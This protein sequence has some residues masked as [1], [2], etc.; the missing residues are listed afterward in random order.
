MTIRLSRLAPF[1]LPLCLAGCSLLPT[2]RHLPVP[3]APARVQTLSPD[4][5]VAS[6]NQR[7]NALESLNAKV[8]IQASIEKPKEGLEK[9]YTTFPAIILLRKP[10][11]LRV[12]GRVPIVGTMMFD[13]AS[14]GKTFTM[15][16]PSRKEAIEGPNS[17][18]KVSP[19][20]IENMRPSF[21]FDAMVVRGLAPD[22][23][24]SVTAD[25]ETVEDPSK[26]H[27][28]LKYEYVLSIMRQKPNSHQNVTQRVVIFDRATM[29]PYEQDVYNSNGDLE[30]KVLYSNYR[31][32][33]SINY[34]STITIECPREAY[35]IVLTVVTVTENQTLKDDQ[36]QVKVP[37]GTEIKNLQ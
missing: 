18:T 10:E 19:D 1:C 24:Y 2:T 28:L 11:M 26:K 6:L 27:L 29:L 16:I 13:M 33:G 37:E 36:F 20:Q 5:V 21:F 17:V 22:D 8:T 25:S 12:Y 35:H 15:Y 14:D 31:D 9:Q 4:E 34:P 32:Y 7:W 30:T 23:F 3:K